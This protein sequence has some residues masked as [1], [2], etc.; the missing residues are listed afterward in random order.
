MAGRRYVSGQGP[1]RTKPRIGV[2]TAI[3]MIS[4]ALLCDGL[5]IALSA[6]ASIKTIGIVFMPVAWL[7]S[8]AVM[9]TFF[10]WFTFARVNYF[11]RNLSVSIFAIVAEMVPFLNLL[12][13]ITFGVAA[14]IFTSRH[15]DGKSS[16]FLRAKKRY[17][18]MTEM[19]Q[20]EARLGAKKRFARD[21]ANRAAQRVAGREEQP[22]APMDFA[23]AEA[24]LRRRRARNPDIEATL[25]DPEEEATRK[26]QEKR[27][28]RRADWF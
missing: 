26:D 28:T 5:Q 24:E 13:S 22:K 21:Q 2:V 12:P 27:S 3:F 18:G 25:Y 4:L 7:L 9:F 15:E 20:V 14:L 23:S 8:V 16:L 17:E 11:D 1:V 10:L 6:L 19:E